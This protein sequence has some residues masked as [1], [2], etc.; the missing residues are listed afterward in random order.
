MHHLDSGLETNSTT[1]IKD[2]KNKLNN[3]LKTSK[4]SKYQ[5]NIKKLRNRIM[6]MKD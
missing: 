6:Q 3:S 5:L 4:L 1:L 2:L